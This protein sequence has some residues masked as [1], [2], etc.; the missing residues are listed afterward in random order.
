MFLF[1]GLFLKIACSYLALSLSLN[2]VSISS[3]HACWRD[4]EA[5]RPWS[6]RYSDDE[7]EG[8]CET[9]AEFSLRGG[10]IAR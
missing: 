7:R 2:F 1:H 4:D 3:S 8:S 6:C 5:I 9:F 10:P